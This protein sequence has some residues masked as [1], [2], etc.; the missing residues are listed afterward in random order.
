[1]N[2]KDAKWND[3]VRR[4]EIGMLSKKLW[5]IKCTWWL[6]ASKRNPVITKCRKSLTFQFPLFYCC[7]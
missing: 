5:I 7:V 6:K 3:N 4:M 1:M 2:E